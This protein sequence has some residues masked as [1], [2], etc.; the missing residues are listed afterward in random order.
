MKNLS[1]S[2]RKISLRMF[3]THE[4]DTSVEV[5]LR[6]LDPDKLFVKGKTIVMDGK[7]F[8]DWD[9]LLLAIEEKK[10]TEPVEIMQMET[11]V[12]G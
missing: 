4:G 1:S 5:L 3:P 8:T 7:L 9:N 10:D 11:I 6:E 12:G 2:T